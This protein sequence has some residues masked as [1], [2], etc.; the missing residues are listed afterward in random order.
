MPVF[1]SKESSGPVVNAGST[2]PGSVPPALRYRQNRRSRLSL[3]LALSL[4]LHFQL[5]LYQL[6][7]FVAAS[8]IELALRIEAGGCLHF[9]QSFLIAVH[10]H[11]AGRQRVVVVRRSIEAKG[12]AEFFFRRRK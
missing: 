11:Q 8:L 3:L 1:Q 7:E 4:A 12:L 6:L 5:R 9:R 2:V 10:G